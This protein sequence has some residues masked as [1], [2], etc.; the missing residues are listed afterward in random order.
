MDSG[1]LVLYSFFFSF[2]RD[3]MIGLQECG[4]APPRAPPSGSRARERTVHAID[5]CNNHLQRARLNA[6]LTAARSSYNDR[7]Q[8]HSNG[9]SSGI[10]KRQQHLAPDFLY[11]SNSSLELLDHG[12]RP[13]NTSSPTLKREYGSHGSIDVIDRPVPLSGTVS[14]SFFEM[15]QDYRP[16]AWGAIA[17]DQRSPGPSEYLRV[18]GDAHGSR[19]GAGNV[20]G[21]EES[22]S[23][24]QL[25]PQS[26]KLRLKLS[27]LWNNGVNGGSVKNQKQTMDDS[28]VN[29]SASSSSVVLSG[30][31]EEIA[32]RRA[33]AHYDCQ[34]LTTNLGYAV[35]IRRN[36]LAK[37]R[38]TTTGA[39]AASLFARSST[40]DGENGDEDFGDGQNNDLV[41]SCP[42]FRNE[43]GGEEERIVSLTRL[44]NGSSNHRR[45]LHRPPL[46]YGVAVLEF[47]L[48]ETH[49]RH[50]TCPY[51]RLPRPIESVDQGALYYR[52]YFL[53]QGKIIMYNCILTLVLYGHLW[54]P[55]TMASIF[56]KYLLFSSYM[57]IRDVKR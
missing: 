51:Q 17:T 39:S 14:E 23:T 42:F 7:H 8:H 15:L 9:G 25:T 57:Q 55:Y 26:P 40:P 32:R 10:L 6:G 48:G 16:A 37:R 52:K 38:N 34:S 44:Q 11:R 43:I 31:A 56:S 49:W 29:T 21:S 41:A 12:G 46:A 35:R 36:L 50:S 3:G 45:P 2:Q 28:V 53:S 13:S 33:F 54:L 47:P 4:P 24:Y 20:L 5:Y 18:K 22:S 19:E 30:E 1:M 27:K